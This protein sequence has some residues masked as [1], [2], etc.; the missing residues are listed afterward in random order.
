LLESGHSTKADLR[1]PADFQQFMALA[2]TV[3]NGRFPWLRVSGTEA[4]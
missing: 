1:N 3:R 4:G 2:A